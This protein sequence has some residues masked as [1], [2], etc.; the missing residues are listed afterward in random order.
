MNKPTRRSFLEVGAVSV[1]GTGAVHAA[2]ETLALNGGPKAVTFPAERQAAIS[3]WPRY[4]EKDKKLVVDLLD[5]NAG[6][7]E[8]PLLENVL[9]GYLNAP[10]VKAHCNGTGALMSL[11]FALDLPPGSEIMAPSYTAWATTAPMHLFKYV[12][13]FV[14]INPRTHTFDLEYAAK[15]L[16]PRTRAVLPMHSFGNPSDMDH[17]S[18]FARKHGLIVLEDAAQAQGA[19]L[20]GKPMGTWGDIGIFSFQASKILPAIEGG[21]GVYQKR[22]YYER[23]TVFG[24]YELP[25]SFPADS[26]YRVYQGTGMGPKLRIHPLGAA[27][28]RMQLQGMDERNAFLDAQMRRLTDHLIEL[29]G[30]S[31]PFT[32]PEAKRVYWA[33]LI[34]FI[35]EEKA[36]CPK[37]KLMKALAAEGV[38][39]SPGNYDEQHKYKLYSE[40]KWWH[41]PPVIPASLPGTEE[42]NRTAVRLPLWY[43]DASELIAQYIKAFEK[44]WAKRSDLARA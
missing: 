42:V 37:A 2:V 12:P 15:H 24:N 1:A 39:I 13:V 26:P 16:T 35:D 22:E 9:K 40:A 44:V 27:L 30:I 36:G 7:R 19:Y 10:Y 38:R 31:R 32:R 29:P 8:I 25:A 28:A 41:H 21:A 11:F 34:L 17:I 23:A 3:K 43:E 5:S 14:D 6:Y 33:S 4:G 18:D 20:K